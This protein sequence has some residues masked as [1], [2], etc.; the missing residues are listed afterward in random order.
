[1]TPCSVLYI[2]FLINMPVSCI[3]VE[4]HFVVWLISDGFVRQSK[5]ALSCA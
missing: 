2:L 4:P 5:R 3:F 1:M